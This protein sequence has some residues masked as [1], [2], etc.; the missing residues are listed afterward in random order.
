MH[1]NLPTKLLTASA[2]NFT[3]L[4]KALETGY[5][6]GIPTETV[7]GLAADAGRADAIESLFA[8]KG[9][10]ER[11]PLQSMVA[12][13]AE[14]EAL[15]EFTPLARKLAEK[16]LP[17]P[18][19]LVLP[20]KKDC[21]VLKQASAG[22][23]TLAIRI[24]EHVTLLKFLSF[25]RKPLV[26]TSANLS[27]YEAAVSAAEAMRFFRGKLPYLLQDTEKPKGVASTVV[28]LTDEHPRLLRE[29][30]VKWEEIQRIVSARA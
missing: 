4:A 26:T 15:V 5:V 29:G 19:C 13:I 10:D 25:Y 6:V 27:G 23:D 14:A 11:K 7:Y 28:D 3:L 9:R 30:A 12:S 17:G 20:R 8:V 18:L 22:L 16:F 2:E 1:N 21:T 24:P